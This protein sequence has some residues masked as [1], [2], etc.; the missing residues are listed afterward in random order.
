MG[1]VGFVRKINTSLF[2]MIQAKDGVFTLNGKEIAYC[3]LCGVVLR[4]SPANVVICDFFGVVEVP[5]SAKT[6]IEEKGPFIFTL[7]FYAKRGQ[8]HG[9]CKSIRK[10]SI[11]E[12]IAFNIEVKALI[13]SY[14]Y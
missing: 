11:Y 5:R 10:V 8:A 14:C 12:E 9:F 6:I 2:S 4:V 3:E 7:K 1:C 13:S